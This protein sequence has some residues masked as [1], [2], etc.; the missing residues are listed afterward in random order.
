ML[1]TLYLMVFPLLKAE[2][3]YKGVNL[4]CFGSV[5]EMP[6]NK[7]TAAQFNRWLARQRAKE[8][9]NQYMEYLRTKPKVR[10]DGKRPYP[11]LKL[12]F[13]ELLTGLSLSRKRAHKN[14]KITAED[15]N[16]KKWLNKDFLALSSK[17]QKVMF[18]NV[19]SALVTLSNKTISLSETISAY[20]DTI[21]QPK[22]RKEIFRIANEFDRVNSELKKI[23]TDDYMSA[24]GKGFFGAQENRYIGSVW[25]RVAHTIPDLLRKAVDEEKIIRERK[26]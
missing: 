16:P 24:T 26:K 23:V 18:R 15:V 9:H 8:R 7:E 22:T 21:S 10:I 1:W 20:P 4:T 6:A 19:S 5:Q 13:R 14:E 12:F 2:N 17:K 25:H 3:V 11:E